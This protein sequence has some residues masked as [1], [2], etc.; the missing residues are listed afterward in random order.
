MLSKY[1][2]IILSFL[3]VFLFRKGFEICKYYYPESFGNCE[4]ELT[5]IAIQG[6]TDLRYSIYAIILGLVFLRNQFTSKEEFR[7][8]KFIQ[9]VGIGY[10]ASDIID[11][12]CFDITIYTR[13]DRSMEIITYIV[14]Y[15]EVYTIFNS[16]NISE[17]IVKKLKTKEK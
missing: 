17:Y 1:S 2:K 16:K 9:I 10:V 6:F 5:K 3:S 12:Y 7:L 11:R 14:A 15:L 8:D 13:E 4:D